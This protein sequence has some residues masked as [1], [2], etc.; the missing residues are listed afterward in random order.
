M[1]R[2]DKKKPQGQA[3]R[4]SDPGRVGGKKKDLP[5]GL[6]DLSLLIYQVGLAHRRVQDIILGDDFAS[7][8]W[9]RELSFIHKVLSDVDSLFRKVMRDATK[10]D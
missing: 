3:E 5:A 10:D 4:H 6:E 8:L 7:A 9:M 2:R 1:R